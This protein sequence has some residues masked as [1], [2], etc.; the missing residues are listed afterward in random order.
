MVDSAQLA[1]YYP[2]TVEGSLGSFRR[3]KEITE[4]L[5]VKSGQKIPIYTPFERATKTKEGLT[6]HPLSKFRGELDFFYDL[7]KSA[8]YNPL[9]SNALLPKIL[10]SMSKFSSK[11]FV[12]QITKRQLR[13]IQA[14][15]DV[16]LPI[17]I[18]VGQELDLPVIADIHNITA[19]ELV[20]KRCLKR[21]SQSFA[22]IQSIVGACLARCE[23]VV[24][25][26]ELMKDY[27]VNT[28]SLDKNKIIIV[29]PAGKPRSH[30]PYH[31]TLN[32][33]YAGTVSYREHVDLF[34]RSTKYVN[35]ESAQFYMTAKGEDLKKIVRLVKSLKTRINTFWLPNEN[36]L[37]NFLSICS[38]GV[39]TSSN[40]LARKM[41]T[42]IKLFDYMTAGL[43]LVVNDIGAWSSLVKDEKIGLLTG[44]D[45]MELANAISSLLQDPL[46]LEEI[47]K[48][49]LLL[50]RRNYN[51]TNAVRPLY[52]WYK[53]KG[54]L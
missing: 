52:E 23:L 24:V 41:G 28:Y 36:D 11:E 14:E 29:P 15:H 32:V 22:N 30:N 45:P 49:E 47:S 25:V 20:A 7:I 43:P 1:I 38:V 50:I 17:A 2:H 51:W 33:V 19:E 53:K 4:E 9:L 37:F 27:V 26:S 40:D 31:G 35:C 12:K 48:K 8:Y 21:G 44:D 54:I 18:R 16:S 3:V 5:S 10:V 42:P 13:A 6:F 46:L 39:L 34:V